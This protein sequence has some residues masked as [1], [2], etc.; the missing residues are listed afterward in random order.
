MNNKLFHKL[1]TWLGMLILLAAGAYVLVRWQSLP[2]EVATHYSAAGQIDGWGKKNTLLTLVMVSFVLYGLMSAAS[3][4]P[5]SVWNVGKGNTDLARIFL[6]VFRLIIALGFGYIIV[7]S[8]LCVPLGGWFLPVFI[9][10]L[11]MTFAGA[12]ACANRTGRK[13]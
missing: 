6:S 11:V 2:D 5:I 8:A 13:R 12:L 3:V 1:M 7:C 4:I 10:G 9:A